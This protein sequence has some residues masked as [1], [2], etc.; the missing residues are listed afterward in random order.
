[1]S[2]HIARQRL[3]YALALGSLAAL[4]PLCTDLYL[5]ALPQLSV[6]LQSPPH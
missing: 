2:K 5:P 1:M 4:G 3:G 6:E